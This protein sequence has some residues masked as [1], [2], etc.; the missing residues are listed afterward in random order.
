MELTEIKK[1]SK[2]N[3]IEHT[4]RYVYVFNFAKQA[5]L[6]YQKA[7]RILDKYTKQGLLQKSAFQTGEC[8]RYAFKTSDLELEYSACQK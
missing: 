8:S 4:R 2:G 7:K 3:C 6:D 5:S 1:A